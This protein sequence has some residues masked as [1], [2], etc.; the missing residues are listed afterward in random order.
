M[1]KWLVSSS[2]TKDSKNCNSLL[3]NEEKEKPNLVVEKPKY[4][5]KYHPAAYFT[6]PYHKIHE[7]NRCAQHIWFQKWPWLTYSVHK[8]VVFVM[9]VKLLILEIYSK[10]KEFVS[11]RSSRESVFGKA[12][13][14]FMNG[15]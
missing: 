14:T 13:V 2:L 1:K 3:K 10:L 15:N 5:E 6:F 12:N 11:K 9:F 7:K 8:D 4:E